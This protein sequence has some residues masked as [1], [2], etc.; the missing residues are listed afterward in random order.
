M[1]WSDSIIVN[2]TSVGNETNRIG[3]GGTGGNT[4]P[5]ISTS[6]PGGNSEREPPDP[7]PNSEV[8]TLC[9]DGSV[10]C[11]HARVG[12]CHDL[13]TK[14]P[15]G[16]PAGAFCSGGSGNPLGQSRRGERRTSTGSWLT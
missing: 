6:F 1:R 11:R 8:K 9:A 10:P 16:R 7:I 4:G 13:E 14:A 2:A 15:A 5:A 12:H 3:G